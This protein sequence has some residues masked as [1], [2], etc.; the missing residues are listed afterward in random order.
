MSVA[1][2]SPGSRPHGV[3]DFVAT[4]DNGAK[5]VA[6]VVENVSC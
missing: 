1:E 5:E 6:E 4:D 3:F 2:S